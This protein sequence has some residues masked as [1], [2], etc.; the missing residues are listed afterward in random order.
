MILHRNCKVTNPMHDLEKKDTIPTRRIFWCSHYAKSIIKCPAM[1]SVIIGL[2]CKRPF[3]YNESKFLVYREGFYEFLFQE[4]ISE[5]NS[6][7][8]PVLFKAN[9]R[10]LEP[11]PAYSPHRVFDYGIAESHSMSPCPNLQLQARSS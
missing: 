5:P 3:C 1:D 6:L 11:T 2:T 10:P 9:T 8:W 4:K 7:G